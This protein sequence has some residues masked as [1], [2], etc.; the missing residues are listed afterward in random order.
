MVGPSHSSYPF[1][2][3]LSDSSHTPINLSHCPE[4]GIR[5][6]FLICRNETLFTV[7][8]QQV[9]L[10]ASESSHSAVRGGEAERAE[11]AAHAHISL[12]PTH[13]PNHCGS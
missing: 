13:R 11:Q 3:Q 6:E 8:R 5:F 9:S 2:M 7:A 12:F 10:G 4:A 1:E